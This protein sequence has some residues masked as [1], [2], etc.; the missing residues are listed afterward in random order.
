M[1]TPEPGTPGAFAVDPVEAIAFLVNKEDVP[2]RH[3]TDVWQAMHDRAFMVAGAQTDALLADFHEAVN[4]AISEGRTLEQ[5]RKDFDRIVAAHGWSYNGS[6]GW[7]SRVIFQT[8]LRTAMAAGRWQQIQ[9]LKQARPYLRYVHLEEQPHPRYQHHLWHNVV[10]PVDH[11]WWET[12]FA[13][14]GWGCHCTVQSLSERDLARYHLKVWDEPPPSRMIEHTI[15][16]PDGPRTI[17]VPEG[18]DPGFAYNPGRTL[19]PPQRQS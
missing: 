15:K 7:R 12:H 11:P 2:T 4:K 8:N 16:T 18:I 13:P 19:E 3:W 6:R 5:F 9:R 1:A 14:N 10:L 17:L